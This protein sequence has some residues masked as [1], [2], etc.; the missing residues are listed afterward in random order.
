MLIK[1]DLMLLNCQININTK[2]KGFLHAKKCLERALK[3]SIILSFQFPKT[4]L[5]IFLFW[6][7]ILIALAHTLIALTQRRWDAARTEMIWLVARTSAYLPL[8][9]YAK[10]TDE[11]EIHQWINDRRIRINRL[12]YMNLV[13]AKF[14]KRNDNSC[15]QTR[16]TLWQFIVVKKPLWYPIEGSP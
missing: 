6:S 3:Y 4:C 8:L 9:V 13:V 10:G 2:K 12:L 16:D 5:R 1:C 15:L 11:T 14:V 7:W